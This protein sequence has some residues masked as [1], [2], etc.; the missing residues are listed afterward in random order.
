MAR[1]ITLQ[2]PHELHPDEVRAR[3]STV[4]E[5]QLSAA[6]DSETVSYRRNGDGDRCTFTWNQGGFSIQ[7][8]ILICETEVIV[9]V[10]MPWIAGF[11]QESVEEYITRQ[12]AVLTGLPKT[13][14]VDENA[15]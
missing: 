4:I 1:K 3:L 14:P 12:A 9:T 10:E 6:G 13:A 5:E 11:F 15:L 8:N 2:F 7:G